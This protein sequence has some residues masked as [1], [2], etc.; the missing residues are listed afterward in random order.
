MSGVRAGPTVAAVDLGS[1]SFHM[2]VAREV[3]G[4]LQIIDR[5]KESVRLAGGLEK[6]GKLD[7]QTHE[8]A[9]ACLQRFGERLAEADPGYVRVVG[10]NTLRRATQAHSFREQ[11]ER[12]LRHR[13]EVIPGRE[14]ARLVFLGV[15]Q[16]AANHGG[17]RLVVDIGGGS[18]EC[19][20][21]RGFEPQIADSLYMGCVSWTQRYFKEGIVTKESFDEART[22]ARQ[23][24]APITQQYVASGWSQCL[25]SSG[26]IQAVSNVLKVN[27]WTDG[28]ITIAALRRLKKALI[29]LGGAAELPGMKPDRAPVFA[30]G[31]AVLYAVFD[32]LKIKEMT[33]AS[34]ALREGVLYDLVGRIRH[35][36]IRE[37]TIRRLRERFVLDVSQARRV[38][39]TALSL[40]KQV[41]S[42]WE[43]DGA[44]ADTSLRWA[45]ELHEVGLAVSYSGHHRHGAYLITNSDMPGFSRDDQAL[46][47]AMVYG[48]RR[49]LSEEVFRGIHGAKRRQDVIRL[50]VLLRIASRLNRS[51]VE[52]RPPTPSCAVKGNR[53]DL[54]FKAGWLAE[55]P[56]TEADFSTEAKRL[57][58]S[59]FMLYYQ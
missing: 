12:A 32:Q 44:W 51:R 36:D 20:I 48:H 9:L 31:L 5:I 39:A 10:T 58:R 19:V 21:G 30:G 53:I 57:R 49:K 16:T 46:L 13:I 29:E 59:D 8:R 17:Q 24:V 14:E 34:G 26:S 41:K 2:V 40:L 28:T 1:N 43:I 18:T 45:S 4:Q 15:S 35:E 52:P 42:D 38:R 56:L 37:R 25:G 33:P 7:T 22:A 11:A 27:R 3:D 55:H 47:A 23:K 6:G 50:T 54:H